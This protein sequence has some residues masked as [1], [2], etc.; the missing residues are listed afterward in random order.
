MNDPTFYHLD[1]CIILI[2]SLFTF[3]VIAYIAEICMYDCSIRINGCNIRVTVLL[4]Y[5]DI[6][7]YH[8]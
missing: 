1:P 3:L 5:F 6:T 2:S 8:E 4:Q 7:A